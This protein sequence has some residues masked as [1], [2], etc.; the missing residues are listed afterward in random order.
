MV[1]SDNELNLV[2]EAETGGQNTMKHREMLASPPRE[3]SQFSRRSIDARTGEW[4]RDA[5]P[6]QISNR[7]KREKKKEK[8]KN[9]SISLPTLI[10]VHS[11]PQGYREGNA[12]IFISR[13]LF[14][15][16]FRQIIT[17]LT[18]YIYDNKFYRSFP[19]PERNCKLTVCTL[20][21]R[22]IARTRLILPAGTFAFKITRVFNERS[23]TISNGKIM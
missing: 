23:C 7:N 13:S 3:S 19:E 10:V 11:P 17:I 21:L 9:F 1:A 2:S 16:E 18:I 12:H 14:L 6:R 8:W 20:T 4:R 5:S 15:F 22:V